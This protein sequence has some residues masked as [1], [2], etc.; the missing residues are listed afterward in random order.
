MGR[1]PCPVCGTENTA[2]IDPAS[3]RPDRTE[4][5]GTW[6][7][8]TEDKDCGG[9]GR[10]LGPFHVPDNAAVK[11]EVIDLPIKVE[12]WPMKVKK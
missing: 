1:G 11:G 4:R 12:N 9:C 7:S 6:Y 5:G 2:Y 3:A 10:Q 8:V